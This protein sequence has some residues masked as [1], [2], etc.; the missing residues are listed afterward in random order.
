MALTE[1]EKKKIV[2][3]EK[4]LEEKKRLIESIKSKAANDFANFAMKLNLW[5][6]D[7]QTVK[8]E[9]ESLAE[10]YKTA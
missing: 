1:S 5:K 4:E 6:L 9:L 7:K 3:I 2:K 8:S 10:K